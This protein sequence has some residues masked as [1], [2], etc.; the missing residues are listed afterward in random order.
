MELFNHKVDSELV[1]WAQKHAIAEI[2]EHAGDLRN[3]T[4]LCL[5]EFIEGDYP[6]SLEE[7]SHLEILIF[8]DKT[9]TEIPSWV[10]K[11]PR[12]SRL[13]VDDC[14]SLTL[15]PDW[16]GQL[17]NL[18]VL[19]LR[20]NRLEVLPDT[21]GKLVK[22]D[23]LFLGRNQLRRVPDSIGN[24]SRLKTLQLAGNRLEQL[25]AS[26]G[27]LTR[28]TELNVEGNRLTTLPD[29]IG[30]LTR[31]EKFN[32]EN[33]RLECLPNS[34]GQLQGLTELQCAKNRLSCLPDSLG[35]IRR[36]QCLNI[37]HNRLTA[38]PDSLCSLP[39]LD[40]IYARHNR[41]ECLPEKI[42]D[43]ASLTALDLGNNQLQAM[44]DS[45]NQ[46]MNLRQ[47]R[48]PDNP[49]ESEPQLPYYQQFT[50]GDLPQ[51]QR[52]FAEM[53][54]RWGFALPKQNVNQRING[55]I[56]FGDEDWPIGVFCR[57]G[58]EGEQEY[59]DFYFPD[60]F[61]DL[62]RR[63]YEDGR[64]ETLPVYPL[65]RKVSDDPEENARLEREYR[66][67]IDSVTEFLKENYGIEH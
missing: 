52:V 3:I 17:T 4:R 53:F 37:H 5:P 64:M 39:V 45:F 30:N 36:L 58:K 38:L 1:A 24:L 11:L 7:L 10:R 20:N 46:L 22:L 8:S 42:G 48:C 44:P 54:A 51:I 60:R 6:P 2:T 65:G 31:L 40:S 62:H 50:F 28:L 14:P 12:L 57:F 23:S 33:N 55:R 21:L 29:S 19:A 66:E 61:G 25:P 15:I 47:F 35:K 59:L 18:D 16:I 13:Y 34:F 49:I 63:V 56:E 67:Y 43:L 27:K 32:L 9:L 26:I 41:L